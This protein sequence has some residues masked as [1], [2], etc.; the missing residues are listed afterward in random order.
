VTCSIP[1]TDEENQVTVWGVGHSPWSN[2]GKDGREF[3]NRYAHAQALGRAQRNALVRL[4]PASIADA[5]LDLY[6]EAA[7]GRQRNPAERSPR[8]RAADGEPQ[9]RRQRPVAGP[10]EQTTASRAGNDPTAA[11]LQEIQQATDQ[12]TLNR[13]IRAKIAGLD[14]RDKTTLWQAFHQRMKEVR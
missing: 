13:S 3:E 10:A 11:I 8:S 14:L 1:A 4:I 2:K 5:L 6:R 12:T 9:P 7:V